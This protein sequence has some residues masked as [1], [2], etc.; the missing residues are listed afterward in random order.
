MKLFGPDR[1]F[2]H[3]SLIRQRPR[4]EPFISRP[5]TQRISQI[6]HKC[7]SGKPG[8]PAMPYRV[9]EHPDWTTFRQSGRGSFN[10][11]LLRRAGATLQILLNL[12]G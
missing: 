2:H 1:L 12:S 4:R 7:S 6:K 5:R 8:V 3:R 10:G 9:N 11:A